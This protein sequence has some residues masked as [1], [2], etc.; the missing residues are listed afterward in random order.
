M[1]EKCH[2]YSEE[3]IGKI[4][5][6]GAQI[7]MFG[8]KTNK[9]PQAFLLRFIECLF[10]VKFPTRS[11]DT[12]FSIIFAFGVWSKIIVFGHFF[13]QFVATEIPCNG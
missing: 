4:Y 9:L 2:K 7:T 10:E 6:H 3:Y 5:A 11:N 12:I 13:I 1:I 8:D